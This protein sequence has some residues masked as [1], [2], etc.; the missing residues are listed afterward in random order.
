[1]DLFPLFYHWP[2]AAGPSA[3][4]SWH[5]ITKHQ[6]VKYYAILC[7]AWVSA[8]KNANKPCP[9]LLLPGSVGPAPSVPPRS[10]PFTWYCSQ[11]LHQTSLAPKRQ[12]RKQSRAAHF[13]LMLERH[14]TQSFEKNI[15]IPHQIQFLFTDRSCLYTCLSSSDKSL[16]STWDWERAPI[17][18]IHV[19]QLQRLL[20]VKYALLR[21]YEKTH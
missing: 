11:I 19:Q 5:Q 3:D 16:S 20:D 1:M 15:H 7:S 4:E 10:P 6:P 21:W 9:E 13:V 17:N 8:T 2:D 18:H 14:S 12:K